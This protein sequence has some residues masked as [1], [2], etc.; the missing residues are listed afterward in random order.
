MIISSIILS[1][2]SMYTKD[3]L[4]KGVYSG[5]KSIYDYCAAQ[6]YNRIKRK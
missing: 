1:V 2:D 3:K 4:R 6:I 5:H